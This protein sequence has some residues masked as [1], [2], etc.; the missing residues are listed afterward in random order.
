MIDLPLLET[1]DFGSECFAFAKLFTLE[2]L[3]SFIYS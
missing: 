3:H 1:I 2:S